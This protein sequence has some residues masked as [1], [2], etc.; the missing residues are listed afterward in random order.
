ML[1]SKANYLY[2]RGEVIQI[3]KTKRKS[4]EWKAQSE[5]RDCNFRTMPQ[6]DF[7]VPDTFQLL[8]ECAAVVQLL[9]RC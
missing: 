9:S 3:C 7:Q 8:S 2:G 6:E 5:Q 4:T 1:I